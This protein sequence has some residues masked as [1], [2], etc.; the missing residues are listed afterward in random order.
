MLPPS[1]SQTQTQTQSQSQAAFTRIGPPKARSNITTDTCST[2]WG[3][4]MGDESRLEVGRRDPAVED[5]FDSVFS[6]PTRFA[7]TGHHRARALRPPEASPAKGLSPLHYT[8]TSVRLDE[9]T[10]TNPLQCPRYRRHW[11]PDGR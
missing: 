9:E 7:G 3:V 10:S 4:A 1:G 5:A 8:G 2:A 6:D 11:K